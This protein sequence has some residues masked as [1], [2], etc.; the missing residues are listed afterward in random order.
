MGNNIL[1]FT[2]STRS[3]ILGAMRCGVSY[4]T[5]AR[6]AGVTKMT[7]WRWLQQGKEDEERGIESEHAAFARDFLEAEAAV[8]ASVET[9]VVHSVPTL[10]PHV[11]RLGDAVV[12][13]HVSDAVAGADTVYSGYA[14]SL[15]L[16]L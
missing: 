13:G 7:P 11:P 16:T 10:S 15:K 5:A 14:K 12:G 4:E 2:E 8:I 9:S 3:A 6:A 1:N